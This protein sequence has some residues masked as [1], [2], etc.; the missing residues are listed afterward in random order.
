[1]GLSCLAGLV[2]CGGNGQAV[3]EKQTNP[4]SHAPPPAT[5]VPWSD[6]HAVA[7]DR[8][9]V[10]V[11]QSTRDMSSPCYVHVKPAIKYG[12]TSIEITLVATKPRQACSAQAVPSEAVAIALS[13]PVG[14]KALIDGATGL[15]HPLT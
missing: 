7:D 2:A 5:R 9:L 13:E 15:V 12:P 4:G 11:P 14:S 10:D 1:M 3:Q 6:P 8:L